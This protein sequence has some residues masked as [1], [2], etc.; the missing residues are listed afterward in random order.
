MW[1]DGEDDIHSQWP[2][3]ME[4][5]APCPDASEKYQK[6]IKLEK[7]MKQMMENKPPELDVYIGTLVRKFK[8]ARKCHFLPSWEKRGLSDQDIFEI[9]ARKIFGHEMKSIKEVVKFLKS[10]HANWEIDN[11]PWYMRDKREAK[12]RKRVA[13]ENEKEVCLV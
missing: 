8:K 6:K 5:L 2:E 7:E 13:Q 10:K 11:E 1:F 3:Y 9:Y 4:E 12:E